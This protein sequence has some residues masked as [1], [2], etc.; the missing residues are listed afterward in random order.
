VAGFVN[1]AE[2]S[3]GL[4]G[5][6]LETARAVQRH[7][8]GF[9]TACSG[10]TVALLA[11]IPD[12]ELRLAVE[13]AVA[14]LGGRTFAYDA[15]AFGARWHER[16][17]DLARVIGRTF[18]AV[19]LSGDSSC[20]DV[21][22]LACPV[23]TIGGDASGQSPI[24]GLALL[25]TMHRA[26]GSL[27]GRRIAFLGDGA[28][29]AHT[30]LLAGALAGMTVA[31]AHPRGYAPNPDVVTAA[32]D[33]AARNGGAVLVTEDPDH[34]VLDADVIV[35]EPFRSLAGGETGRASRFDGFVLTP[36]RAQAARPGALALHPLPLRGEIAPELVAAFD[37]DLS[38]WAANRVHAAKAILM[39]A[40]GTRR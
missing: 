5:E 19:V 38:D 18:D 1:L 33:V 2:W 16:P 14:E 4:V 29:L 27:Q 8:G 30:V 24:D 32:R 23:A 35:V 22:R 39:H 20:V 9:A 40:L 10:R 21:F 34:A 15:A 28:T 7:P 3:S 25:M 13:V 31:V 26:R 17:E 12:F 36:A 11:Q 6:L 37:H